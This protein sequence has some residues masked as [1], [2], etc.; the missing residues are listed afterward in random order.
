MDFILVFKFLLE[1][2][3]RDKI[4]FVLIGGLALQ[5]A[6][7][8]RTT[9]DIDLL[10]LSESKE[11]IKD[12]MIKHDYEL[13]HENEDVLN[14]HSK[15][16]ELGRVDFL[17]AHRKYAISMLKRAEEKTVF[18]GKFKVKV[19]KT[20]DQIGFKVQSSSNDPGRLHQ[21]IADIELLIKNNYSKLDFNLLR[22]YF[23][24]FGRE[25]EL[26]KIIREIGHVK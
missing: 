19:I 5:S 10:V 21:D 22:E 4:D 26:N 18:G 6:G 9:G 1:T 24:I 23:G 17:L 2:F 14:F 16:I 12:I 13:I 8:T 3:Q 11:K 25:E 20:E 15:H 7:I